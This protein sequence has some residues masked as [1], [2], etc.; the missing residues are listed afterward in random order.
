MS[1]ILY[2]DQ[3]FLRIYTTLASKEREYACLFSYPEGWQHPGGMDSTYRAFVDDLR[4]ANILTWNRQYE[5]DQHPL[6][7]LDF[8]TKT[9]PYATDIE[10]LKS[11]RG[12]RYNLIDN[13]GGRTDFLG[14]TKRL[15]NIIDS[16]M[17]EIISRMPEWETADTW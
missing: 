8:D 13:G 2:E 16:V 12:L 4:R 5:D 14:C 15:D 6:W 17:Y 10:F 1:V 7:T 3:K 11:L 9:L